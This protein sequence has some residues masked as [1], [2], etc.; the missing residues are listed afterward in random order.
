MVKVLKE[1][2]LA[3]ITLRKFERPDKEDAGRLVR[4]FCISTGLLQP[5]D[6]RDIVVEVLKFLLSA[7]KERKFY[8]SAEIESALKQTNTEGVA[9]SNIRRQLLRLEKLGLAEKTSSG[10]RIRE[11]LGLKEILNTHVRSFIIEPTIS[12]ICEYADEI[13]KKY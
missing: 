8:T 4:T 6:S 10:Y 12:R 13:D 3:D 5:G 2:P 9:A 7:R 1:T 11:F